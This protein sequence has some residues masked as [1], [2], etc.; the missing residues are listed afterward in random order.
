MKC[1]Y[2]PT[3][4]LSEKDMENLSNAFNDYLIKKIIDGEKEGDEEK[5][6]QAKLAYK[7]FGLVKD[8]SLI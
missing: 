6:K 4:P 8:H 2:K 1:N 3:K 5:V 7:L